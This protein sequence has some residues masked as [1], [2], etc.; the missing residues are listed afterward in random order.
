MDDDAS[1]AS[2]VVNGAGGAASGASGAASGGAGE[3]AMLCFTSVGI[4]GNFPHEHEL[5]IAASDVLVG[6]A[7]L[8]TLFGDHGH[9][10]IFDE[11]DFA[12]LAAGEAVEKVS[13]SAAPGPHVHGVRVVCG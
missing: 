8:Y 9:N 1:G 2:G 6:K 7:R 5:V 12:R 10:V 13:S 11:Q 3:Q 4:G